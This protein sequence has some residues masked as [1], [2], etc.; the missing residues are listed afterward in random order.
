MTTERSPPEVEN[1]RPSHIGHNAVSYPTGTAQEI[2]M[3]AQTVQ[4]E[5]RGHARHPVDRIVRAFPTIG[6]AGRHWLGRLYD[7]SRSGLRLVAERR[8]EKNTFLNVRID[9][10][11]GDELLS[12]FAQVVHVTSLADG[13]WSMGCRF[14]KV[15]NE[16]DFNELLHGAQG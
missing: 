2:I 5:R 10:D 4:T 15:L 11:Q 9:D 14:T 13:Y 1:N 16:R 3:G 12:L 7:V 8:F 6:G